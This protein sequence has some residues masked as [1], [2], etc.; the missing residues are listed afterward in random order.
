MGP[1]L[2]FRAFAS[3]KTGSRSTNGDANIQGVHRL[4]F[5]LKPPR[6]LIDACFEAMED[7][8]RGWAWQD[9]EQLHVTMRF[10]GEVDGHQADDIADALLGFRGKAVDIGIDG[11]GWF[12]HGPRGA[13]F[14]RVTPKA[15]LEALHEK[16]DRMLVRL[17]HP[18]ERRAYQPHITLARR[19]SGAGSPQEW[20]ARMAGLKAA[21]VGVRAITLFESGLGRHGANYE[22]LL[23]APLSA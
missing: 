19:R 18:P 11:V 10:I 9:E 17:G 8:P 5:A 14:A 1:I 23:D 2:S 15:P 7:G 3:R 20:L 22:P 21:P 13:L 16:L 12:D 6:A 4:F